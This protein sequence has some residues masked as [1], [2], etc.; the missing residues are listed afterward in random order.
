MDI[1]NE[2]ERKP[3]PGYFRLCNDDGEFR[4][5]DAN[6]RR[7][8][9][10]PE[11]GTPVVAVAASLTTNLSNATQNDV[12]FTAK[13]AGA[14]GNS[15]SVAYV[16]SGTGSTATVAVVEK[17]ITITAG[18]A[19]TADTMKAAVEASTEAAALVSVADKSGND[20]TGVIDTLA[21][22]ALSG[23]VNATEG[24]KGDQLIDADY[25]YTATA[26]VEVYSTS[27]WEKSAVAAV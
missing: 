2:P 15:I 4:I 25:L 20:G 22:T 7:Y 19:C 1:K 18:S 10:R 6:N 26:N 27:G 12:V 5:L 11:P 8:R 9:L 3:Q 13:I 21:A 17:A 16:I 23:G 14:A 24:S